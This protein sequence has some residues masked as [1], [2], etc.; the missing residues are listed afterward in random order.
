MKRAMALDVGKKRIGVAISDLLGLIAQGYGTIQR[1]GDAE[2]I[3]RI[4]EIV[5][6][7]E[8]GTVI[9]GRPVMLSGRV[10]EMAEEADRFARKVAGRLNIKTVMVDERLTT[11]EAEKLL[12]SADLSRKRRR[13]V[14][15]KIAAQL[16]LQ[17][18]LDRESASV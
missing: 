2:A 16:I 4:G 9:V 15:D 7:K 12:I 14:R 13:A 6:E 10:G 8:V 5:R 18:Y 11:A 17:K 3:D 1:E